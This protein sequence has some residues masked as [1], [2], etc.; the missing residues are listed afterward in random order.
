[1][2][3]RVLLIGNTGVSSIDDEAYFGRYVDFLQGSV[4]QDSDIQVEYTFFDDLYIAVGD[5]SFTIYDTRNQR[6]LSE[7]DV[8]LLRGTAFRQYVDVVKAISSYAAEHNMRSINDY[9]G[10]R[11]SSKLTQ[12]VQFHQLGLPVALSVYVT[13]AVLQAKYPLGFDFPCIMKATFGSHGNDNYLVKS[14]EEAVE[15][16]G[17]DPKKK[18]VLQRFVPND[19]DY[20]L[21]VI[22]DEVAVIG[23]SPVEGS[24][25]NNTSQGGVAQLEQA[26][27]V[28]EAIIEG[29]KRITKHLN[30]SISGVDVLADKVTGEFYFLEVNAQ[31]QLMTGALLDVKSDM[32]GRYLRAVSESRSSG[33]NG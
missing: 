6:Q 5:D 2:A 9:S 27:V 20:R 29:A 26:G 19:K 17:R 30:M 3:M 15:I 25:L 11:D 14:M 24:H 22:D 12:A 18:F 33:A 21:L 32:M 28:P 1:V 7:S 8:V 13:E 4:G 16:A 10:F 23:R 31:P